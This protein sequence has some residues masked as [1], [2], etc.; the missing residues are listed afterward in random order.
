MK[1]E[2][3]TRTARR[4]FAHRYCLALYWLQAERWPGWLDDEWFLRAVRYHGAEIEK[5]EALGVEVAFV[6]GGP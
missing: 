1:R 3:R 2:S 5:L 4:I 6:Y